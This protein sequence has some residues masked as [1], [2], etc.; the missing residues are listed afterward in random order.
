MPSG[1]VLVQGWISPSRRESPSEASRHPIQPPVPEQPQPLVERQVRW[2]GA[3]I[4]SQVASEA[5]DLATRE[6]PSQALSRRAA[7]A[8]EAVRDEASVQPALRRVYERTSPTRH[9]QHYGFDR[10][11]R[12]EVGSP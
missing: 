11:R 12:V 6:D 3:D 2:S 5:R 8:S 4:E 10:G 7:A 1:G 9:P